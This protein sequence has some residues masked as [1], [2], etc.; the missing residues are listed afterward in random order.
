[1]DLVLR[2]DRLYEGRIASLQRAVA[3]FVMFHELGKRVQ[4]FVSC[5]DLHVRVLVR[6][7][8][9]HIRADRPG[10]ASFDNRPMPVLSVL[11]S[12]R[13]RIA[14]VAHLDLGIPRL[15]YVTVSPRPPP[16]LFPSPLHLFLAHMLLLHRDDDF[17]GD[18]R[19]RTA[20]AGGSRRSGAHVQRRVERGLTLI[21]WRLQQH[22]QHNENRNHGVPCQVNGRAFIST[23]TSV[24]SKWRS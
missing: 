7:H 19:R 13:A 16:S 14:A 23:E 1:M 9:S 24:I 5:D 10:R 15:R 4:D 11:T 2:C 21:L 18:K 12:V 6:V 8:L 17:G 3:M 22:S 20:K